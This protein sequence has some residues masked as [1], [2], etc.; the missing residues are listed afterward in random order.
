MQ[1]R[2]AGM[3]VLEGLKPFGL[4][5]YIILVETGEQISKG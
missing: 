2:D 3:L 5:D 1:G 4:L